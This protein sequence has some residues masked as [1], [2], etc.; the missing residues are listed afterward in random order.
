MAEAEAEL[1]RARLQVV[2]KVAVRSIRPSKSQKAVV[3]SAA[4]E[5]ARDQAAPGAAGAVEP[6]VVE[7]AEQKLI[8]A[9][10]KLASLEAELPYLLGKEPP[11]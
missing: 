1:N 3:Q 4:A 10:A 2:Q 8:D 5:L 6:A 7:P 9:K 11:A